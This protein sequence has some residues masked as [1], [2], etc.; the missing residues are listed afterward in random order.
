MAI[1]AYTILSSSTAAGLNS[2]I[3]TAVASGYNILGTPVVANDRIYV[4]AVIG[5]PDNGSGAPWYSTYVSK[6]LTTLKTAVSL[7]VP[8]GNQPAGGLFV[9]SKGNI[10]QIVNSGTNARLL[11]HY[12]TTERDALTA[13][14]GQMI[15][16]TTSNKLNVYTG[17]AWEEVTSA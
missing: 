17:S 2:Q 13:V 7:A 5:T 12:T 3:T 9:D 1:T 6:D 10:G 11:P 14:T 4:A 8:S 15:Y 16:N